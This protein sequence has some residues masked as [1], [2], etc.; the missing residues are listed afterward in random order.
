[1]A[2]GCQGNK[3]ADGTPK[4]F[5]FVNPRGEQRTFRTEIEARAAQI[6]AGG[7]TIKAK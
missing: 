5:I 1:M 3:N 6:R 4:E 7:G 2:C